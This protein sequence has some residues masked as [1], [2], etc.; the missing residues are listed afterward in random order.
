MTSCSS[1]VYKLSVQ[2]FGL[3]DVSANS[4]DD[5]EFLQFLKREEKGLGLQVM[6]CNIDH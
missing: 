3:H 2:Q 1:N 5:N 6:I 4:L